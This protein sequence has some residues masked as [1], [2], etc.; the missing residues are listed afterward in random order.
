MQP[1]VLTMHAIPHSLV[2]HSLHSG[3]AH[4]HYIPSELATSKGYYYDARRAMH[5]I[6]HSF[7][8]ALSSRFNSSRARSAGPSNASR[9]NPFTQDVRNHTLVQSSFTQ[10]IYIYTSRPR[11]K[12]AVDDGTALGVRCT[13]LPTLVGATTLLANA[14][15]APVLRSAAVCRPDDWSACDA[16]NLPLSLRPSPP[17]TPLKGASMATI[18]KLN[19]C[20]ARNISLSGWP[21]DLR[22]NTPHAVP[23]LRTHNP[24]TVVRMTRVRTT[25]QSSPLSSTLTQAQAQRDFHCGRRIHTLDDGTQRRLRKLTYGRVS[26]GGFARG[27]GF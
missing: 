1:R 11:P 15:K 24:S 21:R 19:A 3:F 16:R 5:A 23:D 27:Y 25:T 13:L 6:S 4:R 26:C 9:G 22:S 7:L 12:T 10:V 8:H 20:N 18:V 14:R 2:D 17:H